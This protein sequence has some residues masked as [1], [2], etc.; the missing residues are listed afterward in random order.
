MEEN[1]KSQ[2]FPMAEL[3]GVAKLSSSPKVTIEPQPVPDPFI[4]D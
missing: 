1:H 3:R 4:S 2:N